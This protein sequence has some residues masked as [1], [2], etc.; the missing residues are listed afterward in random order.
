M[1]TP[2]PSDAAAL[3]ARLEAVEDSVQAIQFTH[4]VRVEAVT[5]GLGIVHGQVRRIEQELTGFRAEATAQLGA[6]ATEQDAQGAKLDAL[7]TKVEA[8][9]SKV[10]EI[11]RRLPPAA[12]Q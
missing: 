3:L 10:D 11:L 1:T 4:M 7:N 9:D 5:S 8:L 2:D 12:G 6:L